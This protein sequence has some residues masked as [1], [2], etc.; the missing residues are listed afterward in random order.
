M[1]QEISQSVKSERKKVLFLITKATFGG[2]QRYVYDLAT[3]LPQHEYESGVAFGVRGRL[4]ELLEARGV[5][6]LEIPSLVRNISL[7]SDI[8]SFFEIR[9][10]LRAAQPDVLH[11]N[12]S[13]AALLGAFAGRIF[14]VKRIIFTAHGWPFKESRNVFSQAILFIASWITGL[15][16]TDV[17]VV[18]RTD[19][20]IGSK[21][22]WVRRKIHY[23]PLGRENLNLAAPQEGFKEMFGVLPAPSINPQTIRL[24]SLAELTKNKGLRFGI[25]AVAELVRRG[26]DC[27]YVV[28]GEG[29]ER[30]RLVAHS[31]AQSVS[32]RIFFPGFVQDA[33]RYLSGFDVYLLPSLKEGMPYVLIEASLAGL[34][35]V[36]T[37]VIDQ[38]FAETL[39][40]TSLVP[41]QNALALADAIEA[42]S[43]RSRSAVSLE[44]RFPLPE[45]ISQTLELYNS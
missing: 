20:R 13:K 28:A 7:I 36:A 25:D 30:D 34:P 37:T 24:V 42:L 43:S 16:A 22:P 26:H 32:D 35:I 4:S 11:V 38:D 44:N 23:I 41:P 1:N 45:M 39:G 10:A 8:R 15:L 33:A 17:I 3:N 27:I 18:S 19:E 31:H 2:A 29:E 5:P 40:R 12:S 6:V 21:M 9:D 14:G